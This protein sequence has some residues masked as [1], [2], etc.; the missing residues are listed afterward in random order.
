MKL[1]SLVILMI[2]FALMSQVEVSSGD[3]EVSQKKIIKE[4]KNGY[5]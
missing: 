1:L 5:K 3:I 2:P 4:R